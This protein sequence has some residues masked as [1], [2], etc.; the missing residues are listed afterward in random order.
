[1]T[2]ELN[3]AKNTIDDLKKRID[4]ETR[5]LQEDKK[6]EQEE[7]QRKLEAVKHAITQHEARRNEINDELRQIEERLNVVKRD[8]A[9]EQNSMNNSRSATEH[10]SRQLYELNQQSAGFDEYRMYGA[11]LRQVNERIKGM[12]W[13]GRTPVGPLGVHM[14]LRDKKWANV[15]RATL[16]NMMVNYAVT[17]ARD[18]PM[19]RKLLLDFKKSVRPLSRDKHILTTRIA[20]AHTYKSSSLRTMNSIIGVVSRGIRI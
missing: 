11:N 7:R 15:L 13:H 17:D 14:S 20:L 9:Q 16:G 8:L 6:V 1:M 4:T 19:L 3:T 12:R 2:I 18:R 10:A 5:K